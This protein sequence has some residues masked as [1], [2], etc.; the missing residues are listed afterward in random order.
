MNIIE[1]FKGF[2]LLGA[3]WVMWLLVALSLFSI[4]IMIERLIFYFGQRVDIGPLG[5]ALTKTLRNEDYAAARELFAKQKGVAAAV[6]RAALEEAE[7]GPDAADE[8]AQSAVIQERMRLEK[9]LAFLGTVGSNAPFIGLLGTVIGI[10]QAFH[11]LSLN[12]Q[13]GASTVMSGISEALVATAIGLL[14]AIPA[15]VSFN[16]FQRR[17]KTLLGDA[18]AL[19]H[20]LLAGLRGNGHTNG[21][22]GNGKKDGK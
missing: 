2:S 13:G 16:I 14:V 18:D 22:G 21:N 1:T 19:N 5:L 11:D 7:R 4:S 3:E 12:T 8:A 20:V 15:V 6:A 10:I 9:N 17:I